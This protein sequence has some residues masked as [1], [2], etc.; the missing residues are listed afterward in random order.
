VGGGELFVLDVGSTRIQILDTAGHFRR[1]VN[2]A[3]ADSRTGLAVDNQATFTSAIQS[4][5]GFSL[6]P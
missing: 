3:Y 4:S 5:T 1:A 2:L 6:Q